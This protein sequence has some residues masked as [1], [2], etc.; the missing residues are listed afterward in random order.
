[1]PKRCAFAT[2]ISFHVGIIAKKRDKCY[3]RDGILLLA[4]SIA[5]KY[6][7]PVRPVI[8]F[9]GDARS[10]RTVLSGRKSTLLPVNDGT[11]SN[12]DACFSV[13][14]AVTLVRTSTC[15]HSKPGDSVTVISRATVLVV[16]SLP[17]PSPK[18][19]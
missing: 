18:Q 9:W 10:L 15:H 3:T 12:D 17:L 8:F 5:Y 16:S 13:G 7:C 11:S 4:L 14:N 19:Y 2:R 6:G 1:M